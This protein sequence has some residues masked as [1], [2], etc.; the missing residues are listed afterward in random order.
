MTFSP[1]PPQKHHRVGIIPFEVRNGL[2]AVMFVTSQTRGRWILPKGKQRSGESHLETCQREGFEEGGIRGT[3]LGNF[4]ITTVISRQT[5]IEKVRMPV[6]YYPFSVMDQV[7]D[8]PEARKRERHWTLIKDA[9]SIVYKEDM[10]SPIKQF[11][12]LLPW[13]KEAAEDYKP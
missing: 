4:P 7:D 11:T 3:V 12:E 9:P 2:V 8:W 6:T 1:I 13:I 10:L 5:K